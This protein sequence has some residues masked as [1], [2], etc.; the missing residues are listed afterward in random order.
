MALR[1]GD[2]AF[3]REGRPA[4]IKNRDPNS[5]QLTLSLKKADISDATRHGY[6]NGL[7][8]ESRVNFN[9]VMDNLKKI[10]DPKERVGQMKLQLD[11]IEQDPQNYNLAKYLR[12]EM[13]HIMNS[14]G[15]KPTEFTI[16]AARVE[17]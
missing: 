2:S 14:Y 16:D 15:I 8:K 11:Q 1:V 5:S 7:S 17:S 9:K 12:S 6:I 13:M 4:A 3:T 10:E